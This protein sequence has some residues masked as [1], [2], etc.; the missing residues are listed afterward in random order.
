MSKQWTN[1][2]SLIRH[3]ENPANVNHQFSYKHVDYSLN[4]KG[5]LQAQQTADYLANQPL[6]EIYAS[7][8][9]RAHETADYI[10]QAHQL[11]ITI[12]ERFREIHVGAMETYLPTAE[13]WDEHNRIVAEWFG[14]NHTLAF[15]AGENYIELL[16]RFRAALRDAT[17]GKE[18]K[19]IA[20]VAHGGIFTHTLHDICPDLDVRPLLLQLNHNCSITRIAL[21]TDEERVYG[22]LLQWADYSHLHG[23]A[24]N[25]VAG[26]PTD[27]Q[28]AL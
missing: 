4:A 20:I 22:T 24:A 11:P 6:D 5:R 18:G 19:H 25:F 23:E 15:P 28:I 8:L 1:I 17:S 10:A 14:G 21:T 3:G 26:I 12:D 16:A 7:P 2:L 27:E 9:K 13:N